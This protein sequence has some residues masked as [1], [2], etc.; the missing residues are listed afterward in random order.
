MFTKARTAESEA[1]MPGRTIAGQY[2][3]AQTFV[4]SA[5]GSFLLCQQI[6]TAQVVPGVR[7]F[8]VILQ[9]N[10][11]AGKN[12]VGAKVRAKL[13][14]A[15]LVDGAVF[16]RNAVL[17][18]EVIES[19]PKTAADPSR[20]A[21]RMDSVK[22]KKG[23]ALIK[24]YLTAWYYPTAAETGQNLRYGPPQSPN[25]TWN[26]QGAYP[27]PNSGSYKPFPG[28][29][30]DSDKNSVPDTVG[31]KMTDHP[32]LMKEVES[33]RSE[34]GTLELISKR[35]TI[36]LDKLTTYVFAETDLPEKK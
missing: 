16:P 33:A 8:P 20:L 25:R 9:Q 22:W 10:V 12:L 26:G 32:V 21:I 11:V 35:A 7:E 3:L 15:T 29:D 17:F 23:S 28:A 18:G 13:E 19:A 24:V 31:N 30:S 27:N 1:L 4:V 6:P 14:V 36:K 2:L 34:D 5:F